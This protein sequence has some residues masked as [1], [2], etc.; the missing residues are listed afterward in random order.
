M[1]E[2]SKIDD[3]GGE[4]ERERGIYVRHLLKVDANMELMKEECVVIIIIFI[5]IIIIT[6][7]VVI[8]NILSLLSFSLS[9]LL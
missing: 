8:I 2:E 3:S 9:M 1:M 6:V 5:I 4:K 7:T